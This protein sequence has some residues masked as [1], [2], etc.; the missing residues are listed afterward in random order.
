MESIEIIILSPYHCHHLRYPH[1]NPCTA[2]WFSL[3]LPASFGIP[4][5]PQLL[6]HL[7]RIRCC[8]RRRRT[9]QAGRNVRIWTPCRHVSLPSVGEVRESQLAKSG[10]CWLLFSGCFIDCPVGMVD[11]SFWDYKRFFVNCCFVAGEL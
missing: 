1:G 6:L 2:I 7:Y 4:S 5:Y 3:S 9:C 10:D 8:P 11:E